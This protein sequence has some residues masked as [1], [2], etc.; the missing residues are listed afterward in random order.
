LLVQRGL[1]ALSAYV[2][3]GGLCLIYVKFI[4]PIFSRLVEPRLN[5]L[6]VWSSTLAVLRSQPGIWVDTFTLM[7]R[8]SSL[9]ICAAA[10]A[11]FLLIGSKYVTPAARWGVLCAAALLVVV[12]FGPHFLTG[13]VWIVP[14]SVTTLPSLPGLVLLSALWLG[15]GERWPRLMAAA[16]ATAYLVLTISCAN[17]VLADYAFRSREDQQQAIVFYDRLLA[18]EHETGRRVT[19]IAF[20]LDRNPTWCYPATRCYGDLNIRVWTIPWGRMGLIRYVSG[21]TFQEIPF[22]PHTLQEVFGADNW[23]SFSVDQIKFDKDT[24]FIAAY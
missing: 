23:D 8:F 18:Y 10:C 6:D 16:L 1:L 9:A 7:P 24:A 17:R 22:A 2:V 14:R 15:E 13:V 5:A 3:G 20:T 12:S 21:R 19:R 11:V 4:H